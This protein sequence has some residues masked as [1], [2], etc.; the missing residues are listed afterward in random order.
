[1]CG[2]RGK[3]AILLYDI[4]SRSNENVQSTCEQCLGERFVGF[5]ATRTSTCC[6]PRAGIFVTVSICTPRDPRTQLIASIDIWYAGEADC[7]SRARYPGL[8]A[9]VFTLAGSGVVCVCDAS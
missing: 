1:M 4:F 6:T 5:V 3:G 2:P 8:L 7:S 9:R